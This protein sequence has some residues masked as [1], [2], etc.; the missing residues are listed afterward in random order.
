MVI[1]V[2]LV[3][4]LALHQI[5]GGLLVIF[6]L[7]RV[8]RI[9]HGIFLSLHERYL[10]K[11][12]GIH[13][14]FWNY[15]FKNDCLELENL[16]DVCF[17]HESEKEEYYHILETIENAIQTNKLQVASKRVQELKQRIRPENEPNH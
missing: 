6:R 2:S 1:V 8:L 4:E 11:K 10:K 14:A 15:I 16:E 13:F 17:R 9:V 3:I 5:L 12:N 7:W